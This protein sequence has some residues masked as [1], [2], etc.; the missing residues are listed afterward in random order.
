MSLGGLIPHI[1]RSK[2]YQSLQLLRTTRCTI[3]IISVVR[4]FDCTPA[5]CR[6]ISDEHVQ[7]DD[8]DD[9]DDENSFE[10]YKIDEYE[11]T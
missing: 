10:D 4:S 3:S 11:A 2:S 6:Y 5:G 1:S 7:T 9:E 8:E